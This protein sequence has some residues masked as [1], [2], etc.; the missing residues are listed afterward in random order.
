MIDKVFVLN[1]ERREDRWFYALGTLHALHFPDDSI[2]RFLA[3][4]GSK[5]ENKESV[6]RAAI[7]DGFDYFDGYSWMK[8]KRSIAWCWSWAS[9]MRKIVEIDKTVMFIM[10]DMLPRSS[11]EYGRFAALVKEADRVDADTKMRVIQLNR[12]SS[13]TSNEIVSSSLGLGWG[14]LG[15]GD[16][17]LILRPLGAQLLLDAQ[18]TPMD[19][20]GAPW[21]FPPMDLK[22][23]WQRR[24]DFDCVTGI[25]HVLNPAAI[26]RSIW[27]SKS[28]LRAA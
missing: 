2:C 25:Y 12:G 19:G 8:D 23:L 9:V 16:F 4:D 13:I 14:Y 21:D 6:I 11:W 3:H 10:D 17:G 26:S 22:R 27:K 28:D 18:A 24:F 5:Y 7:A 15:G 1:I 20:E